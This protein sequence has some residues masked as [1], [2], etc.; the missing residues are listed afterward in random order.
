MKLTFRDSADK[1][2]VKYCSAI[3]LHPI[4]NLKFM[5]E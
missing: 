2:N 3:L 5:P 4:S 1:Y